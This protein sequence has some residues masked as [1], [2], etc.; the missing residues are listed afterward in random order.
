MQ[1]RLLSR[2]PLW[3]PWGQRVHWREQGQR[4]RSRGLWPARRARPGWGDSDQSWCWTTWCCYN[5][6]QVG[7]TGLEWCLE[8]EIGGG[9]SVPW[10]QIFPWQLNVGVRWSMLYSVL[11]GSCKNLTSSNVLGWVSDKFW[12]ILI[13][14]V[15]FKC[16][17]FIGTRN[18]FKTYQTKRMYKRKFKQMYIL[19]SSLP[20]TYY[21]FENYILKNCL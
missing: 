14:S 4:C 15:K 11:V 8:G 18:G 16:S 5:G 2:L 9:G 20:S 3:A 10:Q 21:L 17:E 12:F 7:E 19:A 6:K 13:L 1:L